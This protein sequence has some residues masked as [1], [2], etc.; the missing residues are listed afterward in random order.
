VAGNRIGD[1]RR[2]VDGVK[3]MKSL[4]ILTA[5]DNPITLLKIYYQYITENVEL[6]VFDGEKYV[7]PEPPKKN[8]PPK[9]EI[10]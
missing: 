4:K 3:K 8:P 6:R 9:V 5:N 1:L 7:K 2:F 10:K